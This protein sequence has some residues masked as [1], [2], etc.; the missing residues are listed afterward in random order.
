MGD[1]FMT[2]ICE[3]II[4]ALKTLIGFF[5]LVFCVCV[6]YELVP[7]LSCQMITTPK[8][9]RNSD[10]RRYSNDP[11]PTE[12]QYISVSIPC[13]ESNDFFFSLGKGM[14]RS[15]AGTEN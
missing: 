4:L 5:V 2:Y 10:T 14:T 6:L 9:A 13:P 8:R 1:V 11:Q 12:L 3:S 7:T 15:K